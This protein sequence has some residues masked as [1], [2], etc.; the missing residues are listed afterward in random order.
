MSFHFPERTKRYTKHKHKIAAK[1]TKFYK[2][3]PPPS[4]LLVQGVPALPVDP[5]VDRMGGP[6]RRAL[7]LGL[8]Q[9][10]PLHGGWTLHPLGGNLDLESGKSI[11]VKNILFKEQNT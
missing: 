10:D 8:L 9:L 1:A 4:P 7:E 2:S 5:G 11:C 3:Q 6:P